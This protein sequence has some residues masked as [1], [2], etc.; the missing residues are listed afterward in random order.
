LRSAA[1]G[2]IQSAHDQAG[3]GGSAETVV[4]TSRPAGRMQRA[5]EARHVQ[6]ALLLAASGY[7]ALREGHHAS[8][9]DVVAIGSGVLLLAAF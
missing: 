5:Q 2:A 1:A 9:L 7:G 6:V 4:F 3:R 8:W